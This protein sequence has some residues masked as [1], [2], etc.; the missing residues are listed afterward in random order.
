[1]EIIKLNDNTVVDFDKWLDAILRGNGMKCISQPTSNPQ[2][3]V[4]KDVTVTVERNK[5]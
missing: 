5:R 1:M 2:I 4:G 3:Y